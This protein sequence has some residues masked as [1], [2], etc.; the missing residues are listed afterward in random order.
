MAPSRATPMASQREID[1]TPAVADIDKFEEQLAALP[2]GRPRRGRLPRLPPQQRHLRPAPGRPQ[3]DGA[4][5]GRPTASI[6]AEQLDMLAHIADDVLAGAG[7]TSP[8]ARTS[9]STSSQL[10]RVPDVHAR[11]GRGRPHHPRGLRRHR[12]QRAWAATWPAPARSRC[13]TS[14]RGPRPTFRHFLRHPYRPAPAP[15]VQDQL[16]RLR[17]R[18]RPGHVQRR[19]RHRRHPH[20]STD[21]T[22]EAGL[23]G[24]RRR[25]PRRQPAPGARPRGVHRP[26]GPARPPSRPCCGSSTRTATATTSCGPA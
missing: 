12:P 4:G 23:P 14:A 7:A 8:P 6:T 2:R 18:L 17:H 15:Q 26:R 1:S 19:R 11:P 16:L 9:S 22:V 20:R 13:S 5:Q 3:P 21:G 10:E 25:R 24:V